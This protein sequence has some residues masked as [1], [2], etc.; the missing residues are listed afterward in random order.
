MAEIFEI[1][2]IVLFGFSWPINVVHSYKARSNK[3]KNLAFLVLV[4]V[5]YICGIISKFVNPVFM[6]EISS[7]WYVLLFYV[8]NFLMV[9]AELLL[10]YRN[11][12]IDKI[13]L[14][15]EVS[16]AV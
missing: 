1:I 3:G 4:F 14:A 10:Y 5:G 7:K 11:S 8:L 9:C 15:E 16:E 6:A 12:R 13:T 2:M